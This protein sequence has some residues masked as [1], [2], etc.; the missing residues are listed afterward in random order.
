MLDFTN[1]ET[2]WIAVDIANTF[3]NDKMSFSNRI[4]WVQDNIDKLESMVFEAESPWE[5]RNAVKALRDKLAGQPV[6]HMV[7]LDASNQ[8]LQLYAI[9]T[10]D[11]ITGATCNVAN[12]DFMADAYQMLADAMNSQQTRIVLT[13][14]NCKYAL[15]TTMYGK[16]DGT[17]EIIDD[18][19]KGTKT[20]L[21]KMQIVCQRYGFEMEVSEHGTPSIP[22]L[23]Q[24]FKNA[25]YT[26]APKAIRTMEALTEINATMV[27]STYYWKLPDGFNVKYDVKN[28]FDIQIEPIIT[29][30]G[31]EITLPEMEII[32]Y[33][34][35]E[36]SRGMSPNI[37][38]SIDGYIVRQMVRRMDGRFI[39][40]IHD[41]FACHPKD[42]D[43]M[44]QNYKD[45]LCEILESNLLNDIVKQVSGADFSVTKTNT[46]T[47]ED[48]QNSHYLL[49]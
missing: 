6:N 5:Y 27:L 22:E 12:G 9:L 44:V 2:Y 43:F 29:K 19:V 40:T 41:A 34:A 8:A 49:G 42:C 14:K 32:K 46:L 7:Y 3:G 36:S 23:S 48:I 16:A 39:T 18:L 24:I 35:S 4:K 15:M 45:I 33:E 38:H 37:I 11:K 31:F 26:I 1:R 47:C 21:E 20:M 25:L 13:R 30:K 10:A 28:T 17:L